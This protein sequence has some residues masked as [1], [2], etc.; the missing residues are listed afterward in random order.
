MRCFSRLDSNPLEDKDEINPTNEIFIEKVV[1]Q[2]NRQGCEQ[3]RGF[4]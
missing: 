3:P 4:L 1:K 2:A